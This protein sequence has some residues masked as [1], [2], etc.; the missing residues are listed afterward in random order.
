MLEPIVKS[1]IFFLTLAMMNCKQKDITLQVAVKNSG[2]Y[3]WFATST[4]PGNT[5]PGK[6]LNIWV[7]ISVLKLADGYSTRCSILSFNILS[8]ICFMFTEMMRNIAIYCKQ[9]WFIQMQ[10]YFAGKPDD[11]ILLPESHFLFCL[12]DL[13]VIPQ[14]IW[15][16]WYVYTSY[17]CNIV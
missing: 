12:S 8:T 6:I 9:T 13:A 15:K 2:Q 4:F 5:L 11:K 7:T 14:K 1:R 3:L 17:S 10:Q 16:V